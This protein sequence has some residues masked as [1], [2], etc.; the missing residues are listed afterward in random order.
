M[1]VKS[2]GPVIR[3]QGFE[4]V[5]DLGALANTGGSALTKDQ[6]FDETRRPR[7]I[8][9]IFNETTSYVLVFYPNVVSGG[10]NC[11]MSVIKD[12]GMVEASP[13]V[14]YKLSISNLDLEKFDYAQSSDVMFI[15]QPD[16]QPRELVRVADNNWTLTNA[17]FTAQPSDW[18]AG[19]G[20]PTLVGLFEQRAAYAS[21]GTRPQTI[22]FT[23]SGD[24]YNFGVSVPLVDSDAI[25]FTLDSGKQNKIRWM[26]AARL[27][28]VGTLGGEWSIG[29]AAGQPLSFSSVKAIRHTNQGGEQAK[30]QMVGPV[31]LFLERLG[32][33]VNMYVYDY[34]FDSYTVTDLSILA[35]H[36]TE[37][38]LELSQRLATQAIEWTYQQTPNGI[39][40]SVRNDGVLLGLTFQREHNVVAWHRHTS[41]TVLASTDE[42]S[43]C[44]AVC[45]IPGTIDTTL[46]AVWERKVFNSTDGY[47]W[48]WFIEK[49]EPEDITTDF[50]KWKYLDSHL[51][52]SGAATDTFTGLD[53]L[54]NMEIEVLADGATHP[55]VTVN[56]S[57][58]IVLERQASVV[59]AGLPFESE[60]IPTRPDFEGRDGTKFGRISR[61]HKVYVYVYNTVG[62]EVTRIDLDDQGER[63]TDV[64]PFRLPSDP[65]GQAVPAKTGYVEVD[66]L[67][68][69]A[70][71]WDLS[72]KQMQPL[73]LNILSIIDE[74]EVNR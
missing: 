69:Y 18:S 37:G 38:S 12:G 35:P 42:P 24:F 19:N 73:P 41:K 54:A 4:F 72:I 74:V 66:F 23:K 70:R 26:Q 13:G 28:L 65:T 50:T 53:H 61:A 55:P 43:N 63:T 64:V 36:L 40:W 1:Y 67:E 44:V 47:K 62:M 48:M 31:V 46:Y 58:Q 20:W 6:L 21:N 39:V 27:L 14:P 9:F 71:A 16:V 22:W 49:L 2:Q 8:P 3:R 11:Y 56:G 57:G 68:G 10:T 34:T 25:T 59:V 29:G 17:V 60:I 15:V 5:W 32:K 52:Y 33:V 7:M 30:P 51:S 45:A